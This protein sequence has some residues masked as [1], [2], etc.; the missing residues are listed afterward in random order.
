MNRDYGT[1]WSKVNGGALSTSFK[2]LILKLFSYDGADRLSIQQIREHEWMNDQNYD[3]E[4]T[5]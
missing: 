1:Y 5:R 3:K 2:D 4:A